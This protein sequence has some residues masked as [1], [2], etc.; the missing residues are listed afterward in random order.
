MLSRPDFIAY[1]CKTDANISFRVVRSVFRP[2]LAAWTV[3]SQEESDEARSRYDWQIFEGFL[4][5]P[6]TEKE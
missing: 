2:L 6:E 5:K 3:R 4:P 1:N